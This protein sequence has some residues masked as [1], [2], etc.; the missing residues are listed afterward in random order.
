MNIERL[1][2]GSVTPWVYA[3]LRVGFALLLLV[4]Q[5]DVLSPLLP[6]EHHRWVHGLDFSWSIA[7]EPRLV[8]PMLPG[9][10]L[11]PSWNDALVYARTG[12]ALTLLLG[13]GSRLSA[14]LLALV[15]YWLMLSDRFQYLH[16]LHF[17]YLTIGWLALA[18]LDGR[19]SA[20]RWLRKKHV[21]SN[22]P[23]WP[24][25]LLLAVASSVYLAAGLAKLD[26]SWL[27]GETLRTLE[28]LGVLRGSVWALLRDQLGHAPIA[29]LVALAE[30]ALPFLL[31]HGVTRRFAVLGGCGLHLAV[32]SVMGVSTFGLEM[33]GLL[34]AFLCLR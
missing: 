15:S 13:I 14:A 6:L 29:C 19:L 11:G 1:L 32:G 24:L 23:A 4:R 7:R 16:H 3:Y 33:T 27:S 22:A 8:S 10:A 9:L 26:R 28:A 2:S 21:S 20:E 12:L 17:L 25:L 30:L 18:P 31:A 5:S 34:L